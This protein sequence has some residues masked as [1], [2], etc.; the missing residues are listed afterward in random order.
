MKY[1]VQIYIY[2]YVGEDLEFICEFSWCILLE[3]KTYTKYKKNKKFN[4][5]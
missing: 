5:I 2:I 3:H 1:P 4:I